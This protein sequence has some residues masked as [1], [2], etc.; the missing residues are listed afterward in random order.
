MLCGPHLMLRP[1]RYEV[2]FGVAVASP[3]RGWCDLLPAV[4]VDV[5]LSSGRR[6]VRRSLSART[7]RRAVGG[8]VTLRFV[9][10]E[11]AAC[12]FRLFAQ[13]RVALT[14]DP[15]RPCRRLGPG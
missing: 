15:A 3:A 12:E 6:L 8:R 4:S 11:R 13:G 14:V 10:P 2:A 1:G 7:L 9:M 5:S